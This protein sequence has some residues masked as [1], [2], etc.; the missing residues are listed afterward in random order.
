MANKILLIEPDFPTN[1][2]SKNHGQS[3]PIGLLRLASYHRSLSDEV[4]LVRGCEEIDYEPDKVFVTS[5]FTYWSKY[6][7][8]AVHHYKRRFPGALVV[9]GG[10]YASLMPEHCAKS[11]CD[12][13]Y[14]GLHKEAERFPPAYDLVDTNFQIV[15]TSRGCPRRCAFCGVQKIEPQFTYKE[16]IAEEICKN[17]VL[18]YDNNL[19]A[20]PCIETILEEIAVTRVNGRVVVCE[21]QSGFDGRLLTYDMAR[22]LKKA[23]FRYPRIAWD[24]EYEQHEEIKAQVDMLVSAGYNPKHIYVFMLYNYELS[25]EELDRKRQKCLDWGVQIADCR[26]RPLDRALDGYN[27]QAWRTG[28]TSEDYYIHPSW[29]DAQIRSFRKQVREQNIVIRHGFTEYSRTKEL[30][31]RRR[32]R[33]QRGK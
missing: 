8:E 25:Y 33:K 19:L 28:Q 20:N 29:T 18:F 12:E 30:A 2:K 7:W 11:G 32:K 15:H 22:L 23:R 16:S 31:A 14:T 4:K 5:L 27:P 17:R 6:V 21:S 3:I 9:V 13:V 26:Y 10:V 1:K 24:H